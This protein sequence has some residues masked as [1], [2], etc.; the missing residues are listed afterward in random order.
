MKYPK[1]PACLTILILLL[2]LTPFAM[3]DTFPAKVNNPNPE[4]KLFLRTQ[5]D[6]SS[7]PLGLYYN[8]TEVEVVRWD[9]APGWA[10][11]HIDV[12]TGYMKQEYLA[13]GEAA[14]A[15]ACMNPVVAV[16]AGNGSG[17]AP[18]YFMPDQSQEP[19]GSYA[20]G[21]APTVLGVHG[22][23][24][25][26]WLEGAEGF[27]LASDLTSVDQAAK[28]IYEATWANRQ[29]KSVQRL[30][31]YGEPGFAA[32]LLWEADITV[33]AGA[34]PH[35]LSF[36]GS[37]NAY[38]K[39]EIDVVRISR[40]GRTRQELPVCIEIM[41]NWLE[42]LDTVPRFEDVNFDGYMDFM[43]CRSTGSYNHYFDYWTWDAEAGRFFSNLAFDKLEAYPIFDAET[44]QI[45]CGA[46][47]GAAQHYEWRYQVENALPVM[48]EQRDIYYKS[49]TRRVITLWERENGQMVKVKEWEEDWK[50]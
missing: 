50:P 10:E 15:V 4:D 48:M 44:R 36:W 45:T 34:E 37:V 38:G 12:L 18:L 25:Q 3:A 28:E 43:L 9:A 21:N 20:N 24:V 22:P 11:V 42:Y 1:R 47:D 23:W 2:A 5:P 32:D 8:G 31:R 7:P 6:T 40:Q 16:A 14:N 30:P 17:R 39:Q 19:I 27:M 35:T 26:V 46:K 29:Y 33:Q 49:E 41:D 13:T